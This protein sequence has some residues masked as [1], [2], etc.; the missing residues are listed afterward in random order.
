MGAL[1]A[2]SLFWCQA[3]DTEEFNDRIALGEGGFISGRAEQYGFLLVAPCSIE[4]EIAD[5]ML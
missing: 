3:T 1:Q 5:E 4:R 2:K